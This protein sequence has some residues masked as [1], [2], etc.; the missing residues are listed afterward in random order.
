LA[1]LGIAA[2]AKAD[3]ID[4]SQKDREPSVLHRLR[5]EARAIADPR[6]LRALTPPLLAL[7]LLPW[8]K[9][10]VARELLGTLFR[11]AAMCQY[12]GWC[13]LHGIRLYKD[14]GAT[15]GPFIHL[16]HAAMQIFVGPS[17]AGCRHADLVVHILGSGVMGAFLAPRFAVSRLASVV[18]RTG[19]AVLG[20]A[21]WISWYLPAGETAHTVQRDP[22]YALFGYLGMVLLYVSAEW[23]EKRASRIAIA[24]GFL[25]TTQ[26]FTRQSG[27]IYPAMGA[28]A[29]FLA[30][31]PRREHRAVRTRG[32]VIGAAAAFGGT[33]AMVVIVGSLRGFWFWYFQYPFALYQFQGRI[34][35][36]KLLT[37]TYTGP[38]LLS[39]VLLVSVIA[40]VT[41]K[42]LPRRAVGFAIAPLLFLLAACLV[43]KGW[44]SHAMQTTAATDII[45][46]MLLSRLWSFRQ[47]SRRWSVLSATPA[48]LSLLFT[49]YH[50]MTALQE[51]TFY[52]HAAEQFSDATRAISVGDYLRAHTEPTDTVFLYGHEA[53][54]LLAAER[55]TAVPFYVNLESDPETVLERRPSE[56]ADG[57]TPDQLV[58]YHK[59]SKTIAN[60]VCTDLTSSPPAA[61]VFLDRS[62]GIWGIPTGVGDA[63]RICPALPS[64]LQT[65]Y[66]E[67]PEIAPEYHVFLRN[68]RDS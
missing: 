35:A 16:L 8:I 17:D 49:A 60:E 58:R 12:S 45:L 7:A 9:V 65:G 61:M 48:A 64:M 24:G 47:E 21:L 19:W 14:V 31:D 34:P 6:T 62:L 20:A 10:Q 29:L 36:E 39:V 13:I 5:E 27:L 18:Q 3:V 33:I 42:I 15:D 54:V 11:D 41:T 59:M 30:E 67:V 26:V 28:L 51:S 37:E 32:A 23:D 68:D 40:A 57:P 38:A 44:N 4:D 46:L 22:Y 53:H 52:T 63:T 66:R 25:V 56:G 2:K 50:A 55:K 1:A 43:G